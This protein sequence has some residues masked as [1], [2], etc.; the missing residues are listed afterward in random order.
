MS[1][2]E[3]G[4]AAPKKVLT[5]V[6]YF[7]PG[8][9][10][11]G[12]TTTIRN[13][14]DH[15]FDKVKFKIVTSD[16]DLGDKHPYPLPLNRWIP[17]VPDIYYLSGRN[18]T[19]LIRIMRETDSDVLYLNSFFS[20]QYS[21]LPVTWNKCFKLHL[22]R[23]VLAPRGEFSEGALSI[24]PLK[25]K[26]FIALAKWFGIYSDV[27]WQASSIKEEAE[28]VKVFGPKALVIVAPDFPSATKLG[29]EP[30][31]EK[32]PKQRGSLRLVFLSRICRMKNLKFAISSLR[33]VKG[34]V[35]FDIYGPIEDGPYWEE[36]LTL[37]RELSDNIKVNYLGAVTSAKVKKILGS[38]D[39]FF[40][41]TLGEGFG[42]A[43]FEALQ[44][45]CPVL[46]SDRTPWGEVT[47]S[48]GGMA[49]SLDKPGDFAL[50]LQRYVNMDSDEHA[51]A[52]L[53]ALAFSSNYINNIELLN[54]HLSL[55]E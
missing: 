6:P 45:G 38:Y 11:G 15:L 10:A 3:G 12:P 35:Q 36:C 26:V 24:K 37:I 55:F 23:T 16:R 49:I 18:G 29:E 27:I 2:T 8:F 40:L 33:N 30:I 25:K 21:I 47:R 13:S 46:I 28:I 31:F 50:C 17:G 7:E 48:G 42:H 19:K 20:F 1:V 41:P 5:L 43:I 22:K 14:V 32:M 54:S 34:E 52:S 4:K 44:T 39:L 9:K 51:K 53:C